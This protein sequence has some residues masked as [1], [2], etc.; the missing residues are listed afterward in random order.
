MA[1][2]SSQVGLGD[3]WSLL[4]LHVPVLERHSSLWEGHLDPATSQILSQF[5]HYTLKSV[6]NFLIIFLGPGLALI[7]F[8]LVFRNAR[9]HLPRKKIKPT[10]G[11]SGD[12]SFGRIRPQER[13]KWLYNLSSCLGRSRDLVAVVHWI[14]LLF[15][16][17]RSDVPCGRGL[18]TSQSKLLLRPCPSR[19]SSW[20]LSHPGWSPA[21]FAVL[22]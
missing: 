17:G 8:C 22:G 7:L 21:F 10:S 5:S 2:D 6:T 19:P 3:S 16:A 15:K 13:E 18:C 20:Q 9:N 11:F 1:W 14:K 12:S 4:E